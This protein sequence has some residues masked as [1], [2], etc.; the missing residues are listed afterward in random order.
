M[1]CGKSQARCP[2]TSRFRRQPSAWARS[3][4]YRYSA[5]PLRPSRRQR[6]LTSRHNRCAACAQAAISGSS[7]TTKVSPASP[8]CPSHTGP[9]STKKIWFAPR[10]FSAATGSLNIFSVS[11]PKRTSVRCQMRCMPICCSTCM[12][13]P[14]AW[15][16][17]MPGRIA[18]AMRSTA[19]N[20]RLRARSMAGMEKPAPTAS[21]E[22]AS[23]AL[24]G[25]SSQ[26][27]PTIGPYAVFCRTYCVPVRSRIQDGARA[28]VKTCQSA[29]LPATKSQRGFGMALLV[30]VALTGEPSP[31]AAPGAPPPRPPPH[32]ASRWPSRGRLPSLSGAVEW[33]HSP[34]LTADDR[35]SKE[36]WRM[37]GRFAFAFVS[38]ASH[39]C[40]SMAP[41]SM[42]KATGHD[43][44]TVAVPVDPPGVADHRPPVR[45]RVPRPGAQVFPFTFRPA[46]VCSM[47]KVPTR[48]RTGIR[49]TPQ[50]AMA[51]GLMPWR[52]LHSRRTQARPRNVG[53]VPDAILRDTQAIYRDV[54]RDALGAAAPT[55]G[56]PRSLGRLERGPFLVAVQARAR[57]EPL[58]GRAFEREHAATARHH[59]DDQMRVLPVLELRPADVERHAADMPEQPVVIADDELG[60]RVTHRRAAVTAAPGLVEHQR[61][62]LRAQLV[63][64][65]NAA[66]VAV[67]RKTFSV[68]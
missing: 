33:P 45:D 52:P 68:I 14:V 22:T 67:T 20:D 49:R 26:E 41:T 30:G 36:R 3:S 54:H 8:S 28:G 46:W 61:P 53:P 39:P 18:R 4:A 65:R 32:P 62:V 12:A 47:G 64:Q 2:L 34:P 19:A 10:M 56:H 13:S 59:V 29:P 51:R 60:L 44:R 57:Q 58:P 15:S 23:I 9:M 25:D 40:L 21:R 38:M 24:K 27:R 37:A 55:S 5:S 42:T 11:Q 43:Q 48:G 50:S 17:V 1:A 6:S 66:S 16:C 63:D 7:P 31:A 35:R